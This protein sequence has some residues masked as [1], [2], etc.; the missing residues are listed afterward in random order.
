MGRE[1]PPAARGGRGAAEHD[2][3]GGRARGGR[4]A[5]E[6]D[7]LGGQPL[8]K[9]LL[10]IS[11]RIRLVG[12]ATPVNFGVETGRVAAAWEAGG[13]AEPR[14]EYGARVGLSAERRALDEIGMLGE[15]D[16][17]VAGLFAARARELAVEAAACEAAGTAAFWEACR[18]RFPR[19]DG[20]DEAADRLAEAW[21]SVDGTRAGASHVGTGTGPFVSGAATG[22]EEERVASDDERDPRSLVCAMRRAVGEARLP[23]RVAVARAM[24]PLAATGDEV[25]FVAAGRRPSAIDTARTV[26]HEVRGHAEPAARAKRS[27]VGILVLGTAFGSDE[28]EGRALVIEERGGF[29]VG[30]RRRE[31]ALRHLA[32]R[33]VEGRAGF[34]DTV[35]MLIGRGARRGRR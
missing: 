30:A 6:H 27:G 24:A 14:F 34:V 5:T 20:C 18:R 3:W 4:G 32:A 29:L 19:R 17:G 35:R 8:H 2:A 21:A 33:A 15:R 10:E 1:S 22:A 25:I 31:L 28:Q 26:L 13:E 12:R 9:T 7:R 16:E 11:G 23:F